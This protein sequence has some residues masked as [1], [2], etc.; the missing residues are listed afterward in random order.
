PGDKQFHW[1][2]RGVPF[3]IEVGPRDVEGGAMVVKKR[4][5]RS[6]EVVKLADISADWLRDKLEAV[7][8]EMFEKA[9]A[10]RDANTHSAGSYDELKSILKDKGGFVRC[11]FQPDAEAEKKIKEETKATVR[12][13]PFD[14]Q[15]KTGTCVFSGKEGA[16][17]AI[18]AVA[19]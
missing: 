3:R 16:P 7:Q 2:Q 12:C 4:L 15:G 8:A 19:Y 18:F 9:K 13:L 10:F 11:F 5:D 1:E 17:E 14:A 6:K